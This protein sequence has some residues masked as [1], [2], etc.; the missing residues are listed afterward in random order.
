MLAIGSLAG[1]AARLR[2]NPGEQAA[3]PTGQAARLGQGAH[4]GATVTGVEVGEGRRGGAPAAGHGGCGG[5]MKAVRMR[6]ARQQA[7][8]GG[9]LGSRGS[10]GVTGQR[11]AQA[12][13][14]A[15]GSGVNGGG[16]A[17]AGVRRGGGRV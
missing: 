8:W 12:G 14:R 6:G 1:E 13:R 11:R 7:T 16:G 10:R 4:L 3:I 17:W 15:Y 2:L 9:A 5:S